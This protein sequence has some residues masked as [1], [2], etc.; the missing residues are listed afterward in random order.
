[1]EAGPGWKPGS[2]ETVIFTDECAFW[3]AVTVARE[4]LHGEKEETSHHFT[5]SRPGRETK[6]GRL[7]PTLA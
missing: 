2:V 4:M 7:G 1:M 3:A 6:G 5:F